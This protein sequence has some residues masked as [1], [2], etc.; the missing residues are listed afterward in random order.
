M[1]YN[2]TFFGV[3]STSSKV[4]DYLISEGYKI[5]LLVS[6]D[7]ECVKKHHISGFQNLRGIASK[8]NIEYLALN[9]Y[10]LKDKKDLEFFN[11]NEFSIGISY[12]WQ[13]LIPDN[14]LSK[15]ESG[16]FGFH[17]SSK[18][19]PEGKGRSPLNWS[20]IEDRKVIHNHLFK[21]G[22]GADE[23]PIFNIMDFNIEEID[24][25]SNLQEK[26]IET[27][28]VQLKELLTAYKENNIK[29]TKQSGKST[30]YPKRT[31]S[32]GKIDFNNTLREI[33]NLIRGVTKP[34]PGAFCYNKE[35]KV[36][37]WKA[38]IHE[39]DIDGKI[40]E[41]VKVI[42]DKPVIKLKDGLLIINDYE[43]TNKLKINDILI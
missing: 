40:G 13:R 12:G 30:Y 24:D 4:I 14:I 37:I 2:I 38:L 17:G 6:L 15:F 11:S 34:F 23:G 10:E 42:D 21:Y 26:S 3:K 20:I 8:Y 22:T 27:A 43:S 9:D 16:V 25:I 28:K 29:L 1:K 39:E 36:T 18:Y 7:E 5:D 19:L 41:V 35:N 32:D 33:Y 31:P